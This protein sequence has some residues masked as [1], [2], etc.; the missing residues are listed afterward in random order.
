M[1]FMNNGII[2]PSVGIGNIKLGMSLDEI[3]KIM[4][5]STIKHLE[6]SYIFHGGDIAIWISKACNFV[7]QIMVFGTFKGT[8]FEEF[9]IGSYLSDID[10]KVNDIAEYSDYVYTFRKLKGI[11][12]EIEDVEKEWDDIGWH[13]SNATIEFISVFN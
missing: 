7:T 1:F 10:Q 13:K 9:G 2:T 6:Y 5:K 4:P 3:E 12:F 11:C 8:L